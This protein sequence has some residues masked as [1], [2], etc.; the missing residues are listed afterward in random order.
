V[1]HCLSHCNLDIHQD[2]IFA[3]HY[4]QKR[5]SKLGAAAVPSTH[6]THIAVGSFVFLDACSLSLPATIPV[7]LLSTT[8]P[9]RPLQFGKAVDQRWPKSTNPANSALIT[10]ASVYHPAGILI[11]NL[12]E[13][14][15]QL[16]HSITSILHFRSHHLPSFIDLQAARPPRKI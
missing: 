6:A 5:Y 2:P 13:S 1:I 11:S 8:A 9:I 10:L 12:G 14:R 4:Q 3:D 15:K 7:F 16:K